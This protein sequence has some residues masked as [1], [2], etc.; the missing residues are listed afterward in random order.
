MSTKDNRVGS[1]TLRDWIEA[2]DVERKKIEFENMLKHGH[3]FGAS[4]G[5]TTLPPGGRITVKNGKIKVD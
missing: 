1:K 5:T 3:R 4:R 2:N